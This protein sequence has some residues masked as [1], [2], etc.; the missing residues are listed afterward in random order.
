MACAPQQSHHTVEQN[1]FIAS[2][3]PHAINFWALSGANLVTL[4]P[5]KPLRTPPCGGV[6]A[7]VAA[8]WT[9]SSP[10]Y[11]LS[12][13]SSVADSCPIHTE[14]TTPPSY[15]LP[16]VRINYALFFLGRDRT[17]LQTSCTRV[18][19]RRVIRSAIIRLTPERGCSRVVN[20]GQSTRHAIRGRESTLSHR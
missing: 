3:R 6:C 17:P 9:S 2:Q 5:Q 4:P 13:A 12:V 7:F 8:A 1:P 19:Y 11:R 15:R 20:L 10:P 16:T 14:S 18:Q